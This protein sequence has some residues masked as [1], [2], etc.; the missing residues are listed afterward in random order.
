MISGRSLQLPIYLEALERLLLPGH[1]IAGGG[2]YILK[3]KQ[4]AETAASTAKTLAITSASSKNS[5]LT[6]VESQSAQ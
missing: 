3:A 2:Y 4:V 6:D 1:A 5:I